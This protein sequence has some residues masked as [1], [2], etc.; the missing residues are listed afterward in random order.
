MVAGM[1]MPLRDLKAIYEVL[2]RDGVMVAK[3]DKRPQIKHPE[4]QDVSN[5]Q[6]IRAMG[7]LKSRGYVKETFAWRHFYWYLTNEGIVYLRDYLHLPPE[8][9]PA[10]LQRVRRPAATLAIARGARVQSVEGPTSYVPKPGRRNEAAESEDALAERQG[11]RHKVMGPSERESHSDGT[12][13]FRGRPMAA[14]TVRPNASWEMKVEERPQTV[15]VRGNDAAVMDESRVKRVSHQ[16]SDLSRERPVATCQERRVFEVQEE[17]VLSSAAIQTAA[18]KQDVAQTTVTSALP[19]TLSAVTE[20][21]GASP[22][23]L[24]E[25]PSP[26]TDGAQKP[27]ST[28]RKSVMKLS[29]MAP[30]S[31]A[32]TVRTNT[33]IKEEKTKQVSQIKS[34]D[35]KAGTDEV[36]SHVGFTT[37]T[38]QR[39]TTLLTVTEKPVKKDVTEEKTNEAT[40]H[41]VKPSEVTSTFETATDETKP[42]A[43]TTLASAQESPVFHTNTDTTTPVNTKPWKEEKV[44]KRKTTEESVKPTEVKIPVPAESKMGQEKTTK[45]DKVSAPTKAGSTTSTM[46]VSSNVGMSK[47]AEEPSD[48]TP[49]SVNISEKPKRDE[50]L[51]KAATVTESSI[52]EVTTAICSLTSSRTNAEVAEA[53]TEKTTKQDAM[54]VTRVNEVGEIAQSEDPM[55]GPTSAQEDSTPN[56]ESQKVV[57]TEVVKETKQMTEGSSKS[58]RKKKK[59]GSQGEASRTAGAGEASDTMAHE[60]KFSKDELIEEV[61][62]NIPESKPVATSET[63]TVTVSVKTEEASP[64]VATR[65]TGRE[66]FKDATAG[67][68]E[69]TTLTSEPQDKLPDVKEKVEGRNVSEITRGPLC[70]EG[71]L[72]VMETVKLE[73]VTVTNAEITTVHT[74]TLVELEASLP[75]SEKAKVGTKP[76][77]NTGKA[78]DEASKSKKKGSKGKKAKTTV[79]DTRDTERDI[80]PGALP[81]TDMTP[82]PKAVIKQSPVTSELTEMH[83]SL[84]MTPGGMCSEE[85]RQAAAVLSEA[86]ADKR[87]VEP[88]LLFAEKVKREVPKRKTSS[89]AREAPAAGELASAEAAAAQAQTSPSV[90]REEPPTVAQHSAARATERSTET[91]LPASEARQREEEKKK[92]PKQ[93]TPSATGT[94]AADQPHLGEDTREPIN[95]DTD[96]ANMKRKIVVV[97]EIVEVKQL[98][99]PEAAGGQ[100]PPPPVQAEVRG[101]ELDLDVLEQLAVERALLAGADKAEWDHSL[102]EPEEKT[103]PNFIE[104]LLAYFL[105]CPAYTRDVIRLPP[106]SPPFF[107]AREVLAGVCDD[108]CVVDLPHCHAR[109]TF[110]AVL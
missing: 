22:T 77:L 2:F 60:I 50:V 110:R 42:R 35:I 94:P 96:E 79:S 66:Q 3:K 109:L 83:V 71:Q 9:V 18:L 17:K 100:T 51:H 11:Y 49:T 91:K 61:S 48:A 108:S 63:L 52:L 26:N 41:Q 14:K 6:V 75:E 40:V 95:S 8:I 59:G 13:R 68:V 45:T 15:F 23:I 36:Q 70:P 44:K 65:H 16:Q 7:S 29:E 25:R 58:K 54:T 74:T 103:W 39:S 37:T 43:V 57:A 28:D 88:A 46:V 107:E 20:A 38:V 55:P 81:S 34:E 104:G 102:G 33:D 80:L 64:A 90:E 89:T 85:T 24:A 92:E 21:T 5:L 12:P 97:E 67:K 98:I 82:P 31:S 56:R 69:T 30:S 78:A 27:K 101:E 19:P 73:K 86:P 84:K 106:A 72:N 53:A 1:L 62:A 4:V 47:V 10:S 93:D 87:E 105:L 76:L 99:S 32:T